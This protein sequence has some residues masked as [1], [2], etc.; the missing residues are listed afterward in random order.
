MLLSITYIHLPFPARSRTSSPVSTTTTTTTTTLTIAILIPS[1]TPRFFATSPSTLF[2]IHYLASQTIVAKLASILTIHSLENQPDSEDA[3]IA[4]IT[5]PTFSNDIVGRLHRRHTTSLCL[6]PFVLI[7][8]PFCACRSSRRRCHH[9]RA[10]RSCS[11]RRRSSIAAPADEDPPAAAHFAPP[12]RLVPVVLFIRVIVFATELSS[13]RS[14]SRT[15]RKVILHISR[16][17]SFFKGYSRSPSI[18]HS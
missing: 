3:W 8:L 16:T 7:I 5:I 12:P 13:Q 4:L 11:C 18:S 6:I 9:I 17:H 1:P 15:E 14:F 2:R 10:H